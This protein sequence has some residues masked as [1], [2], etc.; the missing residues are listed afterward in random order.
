M[1]IQVRKPDE[2]EIELL[3][4]CPEWRCEASTFDWFYP[5]TEVCLITE[6]LAH[7]SYDG[8]QVDIS[9][10]D[11]VILPKGMSCIWSVKEPLCKHYRFD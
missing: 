5:D 9:P 6:G 4:A 2:K 10:G 8:G 3:K 7:I 1:A 11:Y